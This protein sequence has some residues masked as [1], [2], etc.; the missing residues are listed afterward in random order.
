MESRI[1][2]AVVRDSTRL[3][4]CARVCVRYHGQSQVCNFPH[5]D[6]PGEMR[7]AVYI[8]AIARSPLSIDL[9]RFLSFVPPFDAPRRRSAALYLHFFLVGVALFSLRDLRRHEKCI[10]PLRVGAARIKDRFSKLY[11]HV[12]VCVC[13]YGLN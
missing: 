5:V 3:C 9:P 10:C 2:L 6:Y 8:S 13:A 4:V 11:I 7:L 12:C 1:L